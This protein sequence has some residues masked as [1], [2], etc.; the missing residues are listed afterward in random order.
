MSAFFMLLS[1]QSVQAQEKQNINPHGKFTIGI[2]CA[3]CHLTEAW[4]PIKKEP[5]FNH[6]KM[7]D[8]KLIGK[9]SQ[10]TCQSCHLDLK[11]DEP[12]VTNQDC[13]SCHVDVHEGRMGPTCESCHNQQSFQLVDGRSIHAQTSFP[14]TGAHRQISCQS[15]HQNQRHGAFSMLDTDCYSCHRQDYENAQSVDHVANGFPTEC[16]ECHSTNG[17]ATS[18]FDHATVSGGFELLGAHNQI[19]CQSCHIPPGNELRFDVTDQNDCYGCHQKDYDRAHG[20]SGFPTDC[21]LCHN[22]TKFDDAEFDHARASGGFELLGAHDKIDCSSCHIEPSMELK[23]NVS[24]QNDCY[25]CHT[26]DYKRAHEGS[27]F[28]TTCQT[29]H[30]V[31][32]WEGAE[33]DH[34]SVSGGFE[35]L[36]AHNTIECTG[37]HIEPSMDLK[38]TAS[39]QNDCIGCHQA[40]YDRAHSGTGFSTDCQSCHTLDNWDNAEFTDHDSKF[41]PIYSGRHQN[42]WSSCSTC[43]TDPSNYKTFSCIDCHEHNKTDTDNHHREVSGYTYTSTACYSC[44][45]SGN[46]EGGDD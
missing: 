46:G 12:K 9:H 34:T 15:C 21:Q 1:W 13:E 42:V 31:N 39:D 7:T 2:D 35:L 18:K 29:C 16:Q 25:G 41:F 4:T 6:D 23:F 22:T 40:D 32:S 27:G 20:G 24:S 11:F 17:W 44:H 19:R 10:V 5:E 45:P 30:N 8:F 14:L 28:P 43:H 36:G 3:S 37:C 38:F 33:F 26:T